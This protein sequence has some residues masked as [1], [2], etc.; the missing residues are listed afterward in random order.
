MGRQVDSRNARLRITQGERSV[1]P[2]TCAC[3]VVAFAA[4]LGL[5][6]CS[7]GESAST[8]TSSSAA[9]QA[10]SATDINFPP[11]FFILEDAQS[12]A[13]W[14]KGQGASDAYV[15]G[16]GGVTVSILP[17]NVEAF[18]AALKQRASDAADAVVGSS[19]FPSIT[20]VE[21]DA[22]LRTVTIHMD[23]TAADTGTAI[24]GAAVAVPA[25]LFHTSVGD[26]QGVAVTIIG[27]DGSV[28]DERT[29]PD[30]LKVDASSLAGSASEALKGQVEKWA[31]SVGSVDVGSLAE[32]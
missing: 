9:D 28:L 5:Q 30:A 31:G 18:N 29:Y 26:G 17:E 13:D 1:F 4:I 3:I 27:S 6:G 16:Q 8:E 21:H 10:E 15:N 23:K 22:D 2:I 25:C 11:E 7:S 20:K 12:F 14:A 24:A 19:A 32:E